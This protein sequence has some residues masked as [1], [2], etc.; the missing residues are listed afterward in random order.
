[1]VIGSWR[2][3]AAE[4]EGL[5]QPE[6]EQCWPDEGEGDADQHG[7]DGAE[8][9]QIQEE[10]RAKCRTDGFRR[11]APSEFVS[12]LHEVSKRERWSFGGFSHCKELIAARRVLAC[13]DFKIS[14]QQ[15]QAGGA[16]RFRHWENAA[17]SSC[18]CAPITSHLS[19]SK[20]HC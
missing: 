4:F 18:G 10:A 13:I 17:S 5:E 6:K 12:P 7:G 1:M 11:F 16:E 3:R 19:W 2:L 15:S 20:E 8:W 14:K 9:Q